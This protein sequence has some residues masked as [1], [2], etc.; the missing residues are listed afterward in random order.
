MN[1]SVGETISDGHRVYV[2]GRDKKYHQLPTRGSHANYL[3]SPEKLDEELN[4]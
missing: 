4:K 1:L 3:V 2:K